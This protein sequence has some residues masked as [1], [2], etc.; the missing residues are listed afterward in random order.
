MPYPQIPFSY[1]YLIEG[2]SGDIH[3]VDTGLETDA[4]WRALVAAVDEMGYS[5]AAVASVMLTHVHADHSGLAARI[6]AET[7]ATVGMHIADLRAMQE[8]RTLIDGASILALLVEWSVPPEYRE[9]IRLA[10][11]WPVAEGQD[12]IVDRVLTGGEVL[13]V[14]DRALRVL[15]TP[16]HTAGHLAL[17]EDEAGLVFTGDHLLPVTNPGIGL[18]SRS[19]GDDPVGDYLA[20]LAAVAALGDYEA[21][22]GHEFRFSGLAERCAQVETHHRERA[23]QVA[24]LLDASPHRSVWE[25]ASRLEWTQGWENLRG[26]R[27]MSALAQTAMHVDRVRR[28]TCIEGSCQV[29]D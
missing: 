14:G 1:S 20:S 18:G 22:P 17:V 12:F 9:E 8:N 25:I 3:I 19:A 16:G 21:C 6:R 13:Q 28:S 2:G 7:G 10:A 24:L 29:T 15:Q 4:N 26:P 23:E 11:A 5:I 27:V